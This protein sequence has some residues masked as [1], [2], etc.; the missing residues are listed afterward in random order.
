MNPQKP[1][2][3]VH[4]NSIQIPTTF[5][6]HH[7]WCY[8]II[9]IPNDILHKDRKINPKVHMETQKTLKSQLS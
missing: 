5:Y 3:Y 4:C 2:L 7:H 6:K 1:D 8:G 9:E